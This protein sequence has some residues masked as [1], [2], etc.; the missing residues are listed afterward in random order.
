MKKIIGS[1]A[2]NDMPYLAKYAFFCLMLVLVLYVVLAPALT[3]DFAVATE[4]Y[5]FGYDAK[6]CCMAHPESW[7]MIGMGRYLGSLI[8]NLIFYTIDALEDYRNARLVSFGIIAFD[9]VVLAAIFA[10]LTRIRLSLAFCLS[11]VIILLPGMTLGLLDQ[12]VA[13]MN[14]YNMPFILASYALWHVWG[15]RTLKRP[16]WVL[17]TV[18]LLSAVLLYASITIYQPFAPFFLCLTLIRLLFA[19]PKDKKG[20]WLLVVRDI[21]FFVI[22]AATYFVV[23]RYLVLPI[24]VDIHPGLSTYITG[25]DVNIRDYQFTMT[26]DLFAKVPHLLNIVGR[27]IPLWLQ[28]VAVGMPHIYSSPLGQPHV[29]VLI[30]L[31]AWCGVVVAFFTE[32]I[33][34]KPAAPDMGNGVRQ[35]L[36]YG[37]ALFFGG[38]VLMGSTYVVLGLAPIPKSGG[39]NPRSLV[40]PMAAL[41]AFG[42]WSVVRLSDLVIAWFSTRK[43]L[44]PFPLGESILVV[45]LLFLGTSIRAHTD[46]IVSSMRV[47]HAFMV[48]KFKTFDPDVYRKVSF[49]YPILPLFV[50]SLYPQR[51]DYS[52]GLAHEILSRIGILLKPGFNLEA[53]EVVPYSLNRDRY[54]APQNTFIISEIDPK[55]PNKAFSGRPDLVSLPE[56]VR[57]H[58]LTATPPKHSGLAGAFDPQN[59]ELFEAIVPNWPVIVEDRFAGVPYKAV[60]SYELQADGGE[61]AR[62]P[63]K[64]KLQGAMGNGDWF[65]LDARDEVGRPFS[66]NEKRQYEVARGAMGKREIDRFRLIF[67]KGFSPDVIRIKSIR[68]IEGKGN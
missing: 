60:E 16:K 56:G 24:L 21:G 8:H 30:A 26:T 31:V 29:Y 22:V 53:A 28:V 38:L 33:W 6:V 14:I 39:Y 66:A 58:F 15:T 10:W 42:V 57:L 5:V 45:A 50:E 52:T 11:L 41:A 2:L 62:M 12:T 27:I 44:P 35:S 18:P 1:K 37:A 23:H 54:F 47:N 68:L 3:K 65:L 40:P 34:R 49:V 67:Q 48:E 43:A 4:F 51:L 20:V 59:G 46:I 36:I 55:N 17:R 19:P 9:G 64:W 61:P 63:M 25:E 13:P 7:H 32:H